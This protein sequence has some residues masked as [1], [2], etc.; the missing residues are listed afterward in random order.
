MDKILLIDDKKD[1]LIS[2]SAIIKEFLKGTS[3]ITAESGKE[4]IEKAV[5]GQPDLILLD[6]IMPK[7]DGF[8]TCK[9]LKEREITKHIP[10]IFI[11]AI[12]TDSDSRIRGLEIGADAFLNKPIDPAELI[13]QVKVILRI[14]KAEKQLRMDKKELE[15][16][17]TKKSRDLAISENRF[18]KIFAQA[19]MGIEVYNGNGNLMN[20]N[21]K[22]LE[23]LGISNKSEVMGFNLFDGFNIPDKIKK[24]VLKG[25]TAS[26]D[27]KF[28]F[29]RVRK[30]KLYE[31]TRTGIIYLHIR[32]T[33][34]KASSRGLKGY[35]VHV[36]DV[37][38]KKIADLALLKSREKWRS[39]TKNSPDHIM[40]VEP[41]FKITFINRTVHDLTLEEVIGKSIYDFTP[42][43]FHDVVRACFK[44]VSQ[45]LESHEYQTEYIAKDGQTHYFGARV[46]PLL[47]HGKVSS[48]IVSSSNIT[49][50]ITSQIE[51]RESEQKYRALFENM[52]ASFALHEVV[53]D[54]NN[55]I[56]DYI[57][58]E[59]NTAFEE[60]T[61]L[62]GEEILGKKVTEVLPGFEKDP[63]DWIG[64]YG[65]VALT[66]KE[67]IFEQ[68]T[69]PL[70]KWYSVLAY[71]PKKNQ[72][73]TIFTDI[74]TRKTT[75]KELEK[76]RIQMEDLVKERTMKLNAQTKKLEESQRALTLLLEDMNDS[77]TI[78][79]ETNIKLIKAN[80]ELESF[81]YSV[82]H[83]LRAPLRA[84]LGF[85]AK[86]NSQYSAK[87]D[88]EGKRLMN[89][90]EKNALKMSRLIDDLLTFSRMSRTDFRKSKVNMKKL[91]EEAWIEVRGQAKGRDIQIE[92]K[93][94]PDAKGDRTMLKQVFINYLSN[95]AKFSKSNRPNVIEV[96]GNLNGSDRIYYVKD[97]GVGFKK[98]YVGKLFQ[99]FQRL[100]SEKEFEGTGVGLA[101]VERIMRKHDGKVWAESKIDEG[102]TFYFSLPG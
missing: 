55:T 3:V 73:A 10:I 34:Y 16:K 94:L 12:K 2:F 52:K 66:G 15:K 70:K 91:A 96:A 30:N 63:F 5:K 60:Q 49:Q 80:E 97:R 37:T 67:L 22:C 59:V 7:M 68:Y 8:E 84:I 92:I 54:K 26:Y 18:E 76:Y 65:H 53:S 64:K 78:V 11:T 88:N 58:L 100:H 72:F 98:Q 56:I 17:S 89:V 42:P 81:T 36:T 83:D 75:E 48:Y 95:A 31:T 4:G 87:I 61:G 93:S 71:A 79:E 43:D 25:E 51:L 35:L 82:S 44:K 39:L 32:I 33:S 29:D 19:P 45:T 74:T 27:F 23:I 62:K 86:I 47:E 50:K 14:V 38:S 28:D 102:A 20:I 77:K 40:L 9:R 90:I 57:F 99:V 41:D 6:I 85:S 13:A 69:E 21:Q 46:A 101:I 1:N 24:K